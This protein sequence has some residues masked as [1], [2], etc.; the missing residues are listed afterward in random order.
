MVTSEQIWERVI[1][2]ILLFRASEEKQKAG[3]SSLAEL[4]LPKGRVGACC[5][6]GG[7]G[8]VILLSQDEKV[9]TLIYL[10]LSVTSCLHVYTYLLAKKIFFMCGHKTRKQENVHLVGDAM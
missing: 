1:I 4:D 2:T 5:D 8:C 10:L 7:T 3:R 6:N 9:T